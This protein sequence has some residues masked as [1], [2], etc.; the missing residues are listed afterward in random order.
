MK[1][2]TTASALLCLIACTM[3][4]A[5]NIPLIQEPN[6]IEGRWRLE[7][8]EADGKPVD[9]GEH[10][11]RWVIKGNTVQ[12]AGDSLAELKLDS[13]S[14]PKCIDLNW[15]KPKRSYEGIYS[16]EGETLKLCIN[17]DTEGANERPQAFV[18]EGKSNLRLLTFKRETEESNEP[19]L[20]V[21]G[22]VGIMIGR[23]EDQKHIIVVA[24]LADSPAEKAGLQK[25]DI[26]ISLNENP[27]SELQEVVAVIRKQK[28]GQEIA[29]KINRSGQEKK[30]KLVVGKLPFLYLE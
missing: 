19:L 23:S 24:A 1:K 7:S 27:V 22:F 10:H 15:I 11:P 20:G 17:R 26:V 29:L 4:G 5:M 6:T 12:Y 9:L 18:T 13:G 8:V 14:T 25:D 30:L 3:A 21:D 28:P 16:L 2:P